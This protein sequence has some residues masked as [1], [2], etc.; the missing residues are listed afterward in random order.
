MLVHLLD[1]S[2]QGSQI[3]VLKQ[4]IKEL[5]A[6][7]VKWLNRSSTLHVQGSTRNIQALKHVRLVYKG[8]HPA[9]SVEW[10]SDLLVFGLG[11]VLGLD[12]WGFVGSYDFWCFGMGILLD[13]WLRPMERV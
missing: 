7:C 10:A 11:H 9:Y 6:K 4:C 12:A 13:L 1:N 2:A 8:V 3:Y 5:R